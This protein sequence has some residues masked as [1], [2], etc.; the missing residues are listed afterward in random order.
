MATMTLPITHQSRFS[1]SQ[2]W[3]QRLLTNW[4]NERQVQKTMDVLNALSERQLEDIGLSRYEIEEV[5][6]N[7]TTR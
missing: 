3:V 6:R 5:A 7:S 2:N 4:R 1:P